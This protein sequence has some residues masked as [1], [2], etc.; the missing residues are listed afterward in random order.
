MPGPG[1]D[2]E[3]AEEIRYPL[4]SVDEIYAHVET[5]RDTVR[6]YLD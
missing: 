5:I 4:E 6:K 1:P 3:P 2:E